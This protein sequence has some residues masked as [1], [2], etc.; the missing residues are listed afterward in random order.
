MVGRTLV[1]YWGLLVGVYAAAGAGLAAEDIARKSPPAKPETLSRRLDYPSAIAVD[2]QALYWAD[3]GIGDWEFRK[4][5]HG[6]IY[7]SA[8]DGQGKRALARRQG[9]PGG[10]IVD[11]THV[12]WTNQGSAESGWTDGAV[13]KVAKNGGQPILLLDAVVDPNHLAQ[14]DAN[15]YVAQGDNRPSG[16][17]ILAIAKTGGNHRRLVIDKRGI[18]SM[19]VDDTHVYWTHDG[20]TGRNA[21]SVWV[22]QRVV[23]SGG[24]P[25]VVTGPFAGRA[26]SLAIDGLAAFLLITFDDA[27][28]NK[29]V[30][31]PKAGGSM[32]TVS[33]N[34]HIADGGWPGLLLNGNDACWWFHFP[35]AAGDDGPPRAA[36]RCVGK[37]GSDARVVTSAAASKQVNPVAVTADPN[38]FFWVN[39]PDTL[40]RMRRIPSTP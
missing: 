2:E 12:Y 13:M 20:T 30:R 18:T 37:D 39:E 29:V 11:A 1:R 23:K 21:A 32:S 7:T 28:Q 35:M 24:A 25:T 34:L 6:A 31:I 9:N 40:M 36:I 4:Y 5:H 27:R 17:S 16:D 26:K 10:L 19:A 8:K 3:S 22:L 38:Y 14:D 33:A 15:L